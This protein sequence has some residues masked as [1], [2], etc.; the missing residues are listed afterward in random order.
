MAVAKAI[1]AIL[2]IWMIRILCR[3][4]GMMTPHDVSDQH[5]CAYRR[6][7]G[8]RNCPGC[9]WLELTGPGCIR[10]N[11]ASDESYGF[12]YVANHA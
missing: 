1:S 11:L 3:A 4:S 12:V 9:L 7:V 6:P 10:P 8:G 5:R 2:G